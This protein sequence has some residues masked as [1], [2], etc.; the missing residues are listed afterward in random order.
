M[1]YMGN[2]VW[3][4]AIRVGESRGIVTGAAS[5]MGKRGAV[6]TRNTAFPVFSRV[7]SCKLFI[8]AERLWAESGSRP[9]DR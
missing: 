7:E 2:W 9:R 4:D 8:K 6:D 1:F 3:L 5:W